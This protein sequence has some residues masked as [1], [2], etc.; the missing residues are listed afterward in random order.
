MNMPI[1][2]IEITYNNGWKITVCLT[3]EAYVSAIGCLLDDIT[4]SM[5]YNN[6][7]KAEESK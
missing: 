4:V 5:L 2:D 1:K 6:V 3:D 7:V